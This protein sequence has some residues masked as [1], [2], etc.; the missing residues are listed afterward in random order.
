MEVSDLDQA[1]SLPVWSGQ[2]S[3]CR[4]EG[5]TWQWFSRR[6]TIMA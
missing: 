5:S 6:G 3:I 1:D 2:R 4:P